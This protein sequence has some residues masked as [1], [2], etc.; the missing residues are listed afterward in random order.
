M[1][2]YNSRWYDPELGR[3]ILPDSI[4]PE[5]SQGVQAWDSLGYANNNPITYND[6]TGHC[7]DDSCIP[8]TT[9]EDDGPEENHSGSGPTKGGSE[10]ND[11]TD[12]DEG[13][14]SCGVFSSLRWFTE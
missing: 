7:L 11:T 2:W 13:G 8:S 3:W 6:P 12:D 9:D 5:S 10:E 1:Y 4:V 14:S